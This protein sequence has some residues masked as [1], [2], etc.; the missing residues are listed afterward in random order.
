VDTVEDWARH[1]VTTAALADKRNP[2]AVPGA[3]RASAE[4]LRLDRP[5]RPAELR[6]ATRSS[7]TPRANALV[8]PARRAQVLHTFWHHELQ[9]AEL[10]A[11]ALLAFADEPQEFKAGLLRICLDEIRHMGLY[12]AHIRRLG[13]AIGDFPVRDWFW[14]RV[15]RCQ[16]AVAFVA[17]MGMGFEAAN[18]EHAPH[19]AALFRAAGDEIG[20]SIQERIAEEELFHVQ[21]ATEWFTRWNGGCRFEVWIEKLPPPLSPLTL[22]GRALDKDVRRLAGMSVEFVEALAAWTPERD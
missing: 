2:P 22:R 11:W 20:A 10:M 12:E 18:L 8:N 3:W 21:F 16:D 17:L 1:Y 7:R 4:P 6:P 9:A 15:P 13:H 14:E 19:F 5:G